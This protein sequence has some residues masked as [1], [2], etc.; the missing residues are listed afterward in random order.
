MKKE[1]IKVRVHL[2]SGEKLVIGKSHSDYSDPKTEADYYVIEWKDGHYELEDVLIEC[3]E[4]ISAIET[5][6]KEIN[7]V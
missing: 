6:K 3:R 2:P 1:I 4:T 5:F 7:P